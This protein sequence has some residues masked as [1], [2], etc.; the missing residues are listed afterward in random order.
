[1]QPPTDRIW[2]R[3]P[4]R[5]ELIYT[6]AQKIRPIIRFSFFGIFRARAIDGSAY[7]LK[8]VDP[9][10]M[11]FTLN[12]KP[13]Q[14]ARSL[15]W[16]DD[17]TTYHKITRFGFFAPTIAEVISQI[18]E[19]DLDTVVAFEIMGAPKNM[20]RHP[21]YVRGLKEGYH[22]VKTRLYTK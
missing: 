16:L 5:R 6:L 9:F 10:E 1:M 3:Y 15:D 21:Q 8:E 19:D 20:E 18:S 17:I 22:V 4:E 7:Y 14:R 2:G 13:V 11:P 12:P